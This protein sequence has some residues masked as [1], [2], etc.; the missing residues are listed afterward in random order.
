MNENNKSLLPINASK[1][2]KDLEKSGLKISYL[3]AKNK[4]VLNPNKLG[5]DILPWLA[6]SLS[7][8]SW[9]DDWPEMIKRE[10]VKNSISLHRIKGTKKAI[11]QALDIVGVFGEIVEW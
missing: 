11:K 8:D 10:M 2:L 9:S 4:D 7:I 5:I 6:W 3:E 1:L